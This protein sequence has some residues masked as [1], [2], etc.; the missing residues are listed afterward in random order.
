M[1]PRC[2]SNCSYASHTNN[3][4]HHHHETVHLSLISGT[5]MSRKCLYNHPIDR[6][7]IYNDTDGCSGDEIVLVDHQTS[8]PA[9]NSYNNSREQPTD[10]EY[11]DGCSPKVRTKHLNL[12]P[13]GC[14]AGPGSRP[15]Q[16]WFLSSSFFLISLVTS[17]YLLRHHCIAA[18]LDDNDC[19]S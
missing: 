10:R 3:H 7:D 16:R 17:S 2:R 12:P 13:H 14:S 18:L 5:V 1:V 9:E 19:S 6:Y 8:H 15:S 11:E 4:L